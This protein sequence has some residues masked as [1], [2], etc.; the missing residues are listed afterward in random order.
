MTILIVED[1]EATARK[2]RRLVQEVEPDA[3]VAGMTV[4]VD[5]SVEWLQTHPKPDLILM[6]IELADGQSFE[7]FNRMPV[8]S[9]VIFVTA[10]DEYAIKAFKV[11]SIDYLLKPVKEDDLRSAL[12]KL[13]RMKE[14]F[15]E[16]PD[17][18][19]TS[20]AT[21]LR[22]LAASSSTEEPPTPTEPAYRDR[23]LVKQGQ[24]LFSVPLSDVAYIF[25]RNKLSFLK[26]RDEHEWMIDYTMDE[27]ST[28]LDPNRFFRLNRQVI[29]EL[30][31]IDKV[32]L[33]FNGKLKVSLR[34][35]FEEEVIVSRE[36]AGEFR[37]WLG[38]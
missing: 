9:P 35:V 26:T 7:I 29:A 18:L 23:F 2:L 11:N 27:L 22:K 19:N 34:P 16:Q 32:N 6:D 37:I 14:A 1:E 17:G 33:Y 4:S 13:R 21:L 38:E 8:T 24:R 31:A 30:R 28:L 5:E 20:L 36:K 15:L 25:T 12:M 3:T 10:Y